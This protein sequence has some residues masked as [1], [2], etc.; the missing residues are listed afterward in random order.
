MKKRAWKDLLGVPIN[1]LG[2][3]EIE[4]RIVELLEDEERHHIAFLSLWDFVRARGKS[5][6]A[7]SI[8]NATLVLPTSRLIVWAVRYLTDSDVPRF[9]P[10]DFVI[11]LLTLLEQKGKSVYLLGAQ[12]GDLNTAASNLRGSYPKLPIVGRCAGFFPVSYESNIILAI[13]KA[14]PALIL[15][16]KGLPGKE[17]WL[18]AHRKQL[19]PGLSLWCGDCFDVFAGR[20]QRPSREA[21]SKGTDYLPNLFRKPWRLVRI[22]VYLWYLMVL[23]YYKARGLY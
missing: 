22:P 16:G 13:H 12:P 19:G 8:R 10:F 20:R 5:E 9:L 17:K 2:A 15:A 3:D 7:Q 18:Y 21:W 1:A 11:R 23:L 6:F 14:S 4:Q